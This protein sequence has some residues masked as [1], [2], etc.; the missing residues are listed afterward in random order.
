M[1]RMYLPPKIWFVSCLYHKVLMSTSNIYLGKTNV[2][3]RYDDDDDSYE[4]NIAA[5]DEE[6]GFSFTFE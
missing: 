4:D 5:W 2:P 3:K 6:K 1:R